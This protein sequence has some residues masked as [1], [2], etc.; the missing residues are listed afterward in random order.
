MKVL[1]MQRKNENII[2]K[3]S[4]QLVDDKGVT[5][6][7]SYIGDSMNDIKSYCEI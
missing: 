7:G 6:Y 3:I 4:P 2:N 1:N 5:F